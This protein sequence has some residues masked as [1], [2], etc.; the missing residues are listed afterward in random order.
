[1]RTAKRRRVFVAHSWASSRSALEPCER[2]LR[3][4]LQLGGL[5]VQMLSRK[6]ETWCAR[7]SDWLGTF[8]AAVV[9]SCS[10]RAM[11]CSWSATTFEGDSVLNAE[12]GEAA[13]RG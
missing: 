2:W 6:V 12:F 7:G 3:K 9:G 5:Q 8:L 13:M 11:T 10:A 4:S 1:M